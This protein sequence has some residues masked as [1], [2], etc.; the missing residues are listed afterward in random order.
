MY[1]ERTGWQT[2]RQIGGSTD[3]RFDRISK[4][5][6]LFDRTVGQ[7]FILDRT[8]RQI[9]TLANNFGSSWNIHTIL[10]DSEALIQYIA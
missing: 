10:A 2:V 5:P 6:G 3:R 4:F 7:I 9:G 1:R 8:I